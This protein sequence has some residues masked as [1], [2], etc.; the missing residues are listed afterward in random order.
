METSPHGLIRGTTVFTMLMHEGAIEHRT[1]LPHEA[2][3]VVVNVYHWYVRTYKVSR[4]Q[5]VQE[6][7]L[8]P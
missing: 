2:S 8:D 1:S 7:I 5:R 3:P 6:W 4:R